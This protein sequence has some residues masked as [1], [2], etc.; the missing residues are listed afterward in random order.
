PTRVLLPFIHR[1]R[2]VER[3]RLAR[4]SARQRYES[5][6]QLQVGVFREQLEEVSQRWE[7]RVEEDLQQVLQSFF[8]TVGVVDEFPLQAWMALEEY[9]EDRFQRDPRLLLRSAEQAF[10]N[11]RQFGDV[12]LPARITNS[13]GMTL[14]LIQPGRFLMGSPPGERGRRADEGP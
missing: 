11:W 4:E 14:V 7:S 12:S 5:Q 3:A 13:L 10:T 6:R 8:Q 9:L 1:L 2:N